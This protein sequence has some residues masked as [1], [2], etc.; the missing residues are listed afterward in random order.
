MAEETVI[1]NLE[2]DQGD[3]EK[4]II[5]LNKVIL[6]NKESLAELKKAYKD[7]IIT[8]DE[9]V[10]ESIRV[11]TNLKKEQKD[12][13]DLTKAVNIN[14]NS[15][16][17][18][19]KKNADLKKARNNLDLTTA[20]GIKQLG[21]LNSQI[22][23]NDKLIQKNVSLLE[24]Q[25]IN[26]GN[27]AS[28]VDM[29]IPGTAQL[30]G[31]FT[32][33]GGAISATGKAVQATGISFK[34]LNSIPIVAAVSGAIAVFQLLASVLEKTK[35]STD[36]AKEAQKQYLVEL[37]KTEGILRAINAAIKEEEDARIAGLKKEQEATDLVADRVER[38][39]NIKK[40]QAENEKLS[41]S[42]RIK[43]LQEA[44]SA[45]SKEAEL[46][47]KVIN[48]YI[49][50][51]TLLDDNGNPFDTLLTKEQ[52]SALQD[53]LNAIGDTAK[54]NIASIQ[55][56]IDKL[57]ELLKEERKLKDIDRRLAGPSSAPAGTSDKVGTLADP[58]KKV[59]EQEAKKTEAVILNAQTEAILLSNIK[60]KLDGDIERANR[61]HNEKMAIE[62]Q[63]ATDLYIRQKEAQ[64]QA[65][66]SFYNATAGVFA[67]LSSL[68]EDQSEEQKVLALA[69][70]A[71]DTAAAIAGGVASSQD[72]PYPG[73][74]AAMASSIAAILAAVANAKSV[75]DGYAEGGY[76]GP[77]AKHQPAGVVH[78]GEYV[79]P[80]HIVDNPKY[81]GDISK[82]ES[83]R[84]GYADGG[85]VTHRGTEEINNIM[86]MANIFKNMPPAVVSA[87]EIT[88][89][90]RGLIVKENIARL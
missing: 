6:D 42:E 52:T 23:K 45:Y 44:Q 62:N 56:Q 75:I 10:K 43:L 3:A 84:K 14:E 61:I 2:I 76:T 12:L 20:S 31:T 49:K 9:F 1:L 85:F 27:Y 19:T 72:L 63:K 35:T 58:V 89:K 4:Q 80:K 5:A 7:N 73:N 28:A 30:V 81:A 15:I 50:S 69:S 54:K 36:A 57:N 60:F 8:Q 65:D 82:L 24:Q 64:A 88:R 13:V 79:V 25:K 46:R 70:I 66:A 51:T 26:I 32:S 48:D 71:A 34:T 37:D 86:L 53:N 38:L 21:Q 90:Q 78:K 59:T 22:E 29:I 87:K 16:N 67:G 47:K 18:L 40:D 83:V 68:A 33:L 39:G 74:L 41:L 77:G 17:S 11:Q 55:D